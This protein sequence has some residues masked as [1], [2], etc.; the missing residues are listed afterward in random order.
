MKHNG[1]M[2]ISA[3]GWVELLSKK[4]RPSKERV[5][6]TGKLARTYKIRKEEW[7]Y[8]FAKFDGIDFKGGK[9]IELI[10]GDSGGPRVE[11]PQWIRERLNSSRDSKICV[12]ERRGKYYL[13]KL[14]LVEKTT[15]IPGWP[16][17]RR[18]DGRP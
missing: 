7:D 1:D 5:I 14:D 16:H 9:E 4:H 18:Q 15:E 2:N 8:Y 17:Q 12:T 13:K 3:R 11:I 6:I 10:A